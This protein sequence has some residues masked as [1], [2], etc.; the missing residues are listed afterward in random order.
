[1]NNS[2]HKMA[3]KSTISCIFQ[4]KAY[5]TRIKPRNLRYLRK[6]FDLTEHEF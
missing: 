6:G 3:K 4:I 1:M 5:Q 2:K